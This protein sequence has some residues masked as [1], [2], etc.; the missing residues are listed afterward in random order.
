MD[1]ALFMGGPAFL[2]AFARVAGILASGPFFG[3]RAVPTQFKLGAALF[4]TLLVL[5]GLKPGGVALPP[6]LLLTCLSVFREVAIGA[7]VGLLAQLVFTAVQIAGELLGLQMG[8]SMMNLVD[9][10]TGASVP[11]ISEVY[12]LFASLLFFALDAHHLFVRG[13]FAS[14]ELAPLGVAGFQPAVGMALAGAVGKVFVMAL[15]LSGPVL[16]ALFLA[17]VALGL[18]A[19]TIPQMN[20]FTVGFPLKIALGLVALGMT[21]PMLAGVLERQFSALEIAVRTLLRGM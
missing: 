11:V 6:T 5:P 2:L 18:V 14:F 10:S 21:L 3:G 20:V 15:E 12:G 8:F 1:T 4:I 17:D 19:R 16:A 9:P 7:A 13:V